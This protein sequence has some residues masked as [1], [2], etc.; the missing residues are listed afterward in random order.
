MNKLQSGGGV[1]LIEGAFEHSGSVELPT[2][3][4]QTH[5]REDVEQFITSTFHRDQSHRCRKLLLKRAKKNWLN[6]IF[7]ACSAARVARTPTVSKG[8]GNTIACASSESTI[9]PRNKIKH[10]LSLSLVVAVPFCAGNN[11][12]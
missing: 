8:A 6:R 12:R 2:L 7:F 4:R 10:A 5:L 1:S 3:V 9:N 11:S